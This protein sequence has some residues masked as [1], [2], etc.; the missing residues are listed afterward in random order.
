MHTLPKDWAFTPALDAELKRYLLLAYLQRVDASFASRKLYP[1]L[2]DLEAHI[3][4]LR[5][6]RLKLERMQRAMGGDLTGFDAT[7]GQAMREPLPNDPWLGIVEEVIDGSIPEL[8]L[9]LANGQALREEIA[10]GIQFGPVGLLPLEPREGWLLLRAGRDAS[11]YAYQL[12]LVR[13]PHGEDP[14][15]IL[16]T[17][18]VTS[19]SM[20]IATTFERIKAEL[21]ARQPQVPNPAVFAFETDWSIPRIETYMPVAKQLLYEVMRNDA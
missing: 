12:A 18:Y 1:W 5:D 14:L 6:L 11:V 16:R 9:M 13:S 10:K 21:I 4:E 3:A 7:T 19:Y 15:S 20:G 17:R 8:Q 2:S